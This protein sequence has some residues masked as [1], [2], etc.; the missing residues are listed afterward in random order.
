MPIRILATEAARADCG[1]A[2]ALTEG[3]V[4]EHLIADQGYDS[5]A[6]VEQARHQGMQPVIP[7]RK[8]NKGTT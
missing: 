3:L 1:L 7:P 5:N 6:I 8:N 2:G 4:A